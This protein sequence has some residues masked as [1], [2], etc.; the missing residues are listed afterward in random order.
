MKKWICT[1]ICLALVLAM[2]PQ[3]YAAQGA[4]SANL[5]GHDY[6]NA[7]RWAVPAY[8]ALTYDETTGIY[9]RVEYLDSYV[10]VERYDR[11]L[12]LLEAKHLEMELPLYGGFHS[13]KDAYFLVFGQK[14][15]EG[16]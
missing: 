2:L 5:L 4:Q 9:T 12:Q 10:L 8:S 13:G 14:N 11:Q 15:V 16:E 3:V 1:M 7:D 6:V